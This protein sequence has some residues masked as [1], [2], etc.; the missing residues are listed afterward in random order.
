MVSKTES[1]AILIC[2][3]L[4]MVLSILLF[5]NAILRKRVGGIEHEYDLFL[6]MS[7]KGKTLK[8]SIIPGSFSVFNY[9]KQRL[10]CAVLRQK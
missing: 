5:E 4:A 9:R 8:D 1:I 7:S 6:A 2:C 10:V 3:L